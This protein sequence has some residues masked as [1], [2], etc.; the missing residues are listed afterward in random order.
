MPLLRLRHILQKIKSRD[1]VMT[2]DKEDRRSPGLTG[3]WIEQ[4]T[5]TLHGLHQEC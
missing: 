3:L 2:K 1:A 5:D 4:L